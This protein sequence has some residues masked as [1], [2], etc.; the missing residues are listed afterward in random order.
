MS[1]ASDTR[2]TGET[3]LAA[4]VATLIEPVLVDL[5]F[6]LVRVLIS[7]RDGMTCRS[8]PSVPMAC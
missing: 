2:F 4:Q 5:G 3:G 6:R 1:G 8:W 7:G